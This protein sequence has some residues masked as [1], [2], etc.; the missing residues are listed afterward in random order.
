MT[1]GVDATVDRVET[2]A[3]DSMVD[4]PRAGAEREELSS[5]DHPVLASREV[6]D[7]QSIRP[8]RH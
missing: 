1:D 5:P 3:L 4:R 6:R 8:F 7:D 2:T